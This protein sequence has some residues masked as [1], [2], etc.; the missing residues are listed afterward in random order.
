MQHIRCYFIVKSLKFTD[1]AYTK[2][3]KKICLHQGWYG[4]FSTTEE[5]KEECNSDERCQGVYDQGCVEDYIHLCYVGYRFESS[6]D[7]HKSNCFYSKTGNI[8]S[9]Q[10]L[11]F[12]NK[13][14]LN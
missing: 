8:F 11:L 6:P 9:I 1:A 2:L 7:D 4:E 5:A 10:T 12:S 3:S 13:T 14:I